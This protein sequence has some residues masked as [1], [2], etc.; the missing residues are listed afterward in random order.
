MAAAQLKEVAPDDVV[1]IAPAL[2]G[3]IPG[4]ADGMKPQE[5]ANCLWAAAKLEDMAPQAIFELVP[6]AASTFTE[7]LPKLRGSDLRLAVPTVVWACGRSDLPFQPLLKAVA[8]RFGST[9][10]DN[11]A[12]ISQ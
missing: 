1:E 4:K 6:A 2:A 7:L 5:L 3:R 8:R 12:F 11:H 10:V 9:T